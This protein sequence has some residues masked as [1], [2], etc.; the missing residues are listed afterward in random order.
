MVVVLSISCPGSCRL[1]EVVLVVGTLSTSTASYSRCSRKGT[2][3][4]CLV[5]GTRPGGL[6]PTISP[7]SFWSPEMETGRR[8][9][10]VRSI[11]ATRRLVQSHMVVPTVHFYRGCVRVSGCPHCRQS[12]VFTRWNTGM[13]LFLGMILWITKYQA[14][15]TS[16]DTLE[17]C[18]FRHTRSHAM[19]GLHIKTLTVGGSL[20]A[21]AI[22][23]QVL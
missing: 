7:L 22:C 10:S 4:A 12:C 17:A 11:M 18:R 16:S 13:R 20:P 23:C 8:I 3:V 19:V 5:C 14:E 15:L 2:G 21:A 6:K 9:G 1:V